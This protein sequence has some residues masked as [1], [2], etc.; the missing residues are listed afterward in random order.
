MSNLLYD[1][2]SEFDRYCRSLTHVIDIIDDFYIVNQN[3]LSVPK[4]K[5]NIINNDNIIVMYD[6]AQR[7][8]F[9]HVIVKHIVYSDCILMTC[10]NIHV[11]IP[12][13]DMA[14]KLGVMTNSNALCKLHN[15]LNFIQGMGGEIK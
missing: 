14:K 12:R 8:L 6:A 13:Y 7:R 11:H 15:L 1:M 4:N 2:V 5:K 3:T 9:G 10:T